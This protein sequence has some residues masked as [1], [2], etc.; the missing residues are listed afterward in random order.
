MRK[1]LLNYITLFIIIVCLCSCSDAKAK[2]S[3]YF[4]IQF[5]DVGQGD[6]AL[7]ECDGHYM[8]IDGGDISA[9]KTVYQ[10]LEDKR[11]RHLDI[12][13]ISHLHQDHIGG[14]KRAL[15]NVTSID[16][17]ISNSDKS[18]L[19][20]FRDLENEII[21][22]CKKKK[23]TIPSKGEKYKLGRAVVE[24]IDSSATEENDSLVLLITYKKTRF[25][26]TGDI[27]NNAQKR[28]ANYYKNEA[29]KEFK[30][31]LMKVPHHGAYRNE[32][33]EENVSFY[34]F[35]RTFMPSYSVIS[36]GK[37]NKYGHPHKRTLEELKDAD[38]II[39]RTDLNGDITV[40]SNGKKLS[41]T[42]KR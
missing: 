16:L 31:D 3:S 26:F 1:R 39:Y 18:N 38:S 34:Y 27:E 32:N 41:I 28:I 4:R 42:S 9:G 21:N 15:S 35:V 25:L 11:I 7:V 40:K 23:I 19:S 22:T 20:C 8:L 6:A 37:D 24:V 14:L 12:L 36:V 5:I 2:I 33:D 10:A 29:D 13:A 30:I 17:T